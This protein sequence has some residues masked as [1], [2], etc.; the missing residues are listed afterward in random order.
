MKEFSEEK[1]KEVIELIE[2]Q[3]KAKISWVAT[4]TQL[5]EEEVKTIGRD[6]GLFIE[7][8]Q[9]MLHS[10]TAE[11]KTE[12]LIDTNLKRLENLA[13]DERVINVFEKMKESGFS[14]S[15]TSSGSLVGDLVGIGIEFAI[16]SIMANRESKK[17]RNVEIF[18]CFLDGNIKI[19]TVKARS[20][21]PKKEEL[22][23]EIKEQYGQNLHFL[24]PIK[25][26]Y[27][28]I[29]IPKEHA[30]ISDQEK[31]NILHLSEKID[32]EI[33]NICREI[34]DF[35]ERMDESNGEKMKQTILLSS[36]RSVELINEYKAM[37]EY[38][39]LL[40]L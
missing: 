13:L 9:I 28:L 3:R 18:V 6:S 12:S 39:L 19:T 10:E 32:T 15:S 31:K 40:K 37:Q 34:I 5:S 8:N 23:Q 26:Y 7:G 4:I 20:I 30:Q 14:S 21:K 22:Y 11:G 2:K 35:S 29:A 36:G 33:R 1:K 25:K 24:V 27:E 17:V 16:H 38:S